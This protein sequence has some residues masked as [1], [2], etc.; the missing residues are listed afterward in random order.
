MASF[1]HLQELMRQARRS[2]EAAEAGKALPAPGR[3]PADVGAFLRGLRRESDRIQKETAQIEQQAAA[4]SHLLKE[5][6]VLLDRLKSVDE[7]AAQ[8]THERHN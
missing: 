8:G 7:R 3:I 1:P 5:A 6:E 2:V 4:V